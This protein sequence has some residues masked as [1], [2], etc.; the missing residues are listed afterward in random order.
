[1]SELIVISGYL[2]ISNFIQACLLL[3]SYLKLIFLVK[4]KRNKYPL[5]YF[6]LV[7]YFA[8]FNLNICKYTTVIDNQKNI[9]LMD[10][11]AL[12]SKTAGWVY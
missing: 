4:G 6:F 8:V 2:F 1:M 5:L 3:N 7:H 11:N 12:I 10:R 9:A